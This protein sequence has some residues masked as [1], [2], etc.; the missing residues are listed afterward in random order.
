ME[1]ATYRSDPQGATNWTWPL[2]DGRPV[3]ITPYYVSRYPKAGLS[4]WI[5]A[6][7]L[8]TRN[9]LIYGAGGIVAPFVGIKAVDVIVT[10][11]HLA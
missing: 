4:A 9:L 3:D 5:G 6:A 11:L 8:L 2:D 1:T 7:R 10:V